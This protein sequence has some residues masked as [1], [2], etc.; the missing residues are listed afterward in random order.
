[1][2]TPVKARTHCTDG[3]ANLRTQVEDAEIKFP[4]CASNSSARERIVPGIVAWVVAATLAAAQVPPRT[5]NAPRAQA[6]NAPRAAIAQPLGLLFQVVNNLSDAVAAA[7]LERVHHEDMLLYSALTLLHQQSRLAPSAQREA[8]G[9]AITKLGRAVAE[10]HTVA[11]AGDLAKSE[12]Q[13]NLVQD[14]VE[15][16]KTFYERENL[17]RAAVLA[18]RYTCAA[19]PEISG[20]RNALC[21]RCSSILDQVVRVP[22]TGAA[23]AVCGVPSPRTMRADI[24]LEAP[25]QTG[26]QVRAIL[27][28]TKPNGTPVLASDLRE[29]HTQKIH[30]LLIDSSLDDYHHEHPRVTATPGDYA[31]E[32]TPRKPG[33]YRA[34][35][36][37]RPVA[38]GFH[39]SPM[40]EI[41][42][43]I[44][45]E[46]LSDKSLNLSAVCDGWRGEL[47][48]S[49]SEIRAGQP[50]PARLRLSGA[51]GTPVTQLEPLM[52]AFAH[53]AG[54]HE[55]RQSVLHIH[56]KGPPATNTEARGGPELEFIFYSHKAGF[57]RLFAQVQIAGVSRIFPFGI[58]VHR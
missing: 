17:D 9:A 19:H 26:A 16:L 20:A 41:Y 38:T 12:A 51:D 13:S 45:G 5:E 11:D 18:G 22:L 58:H 43:D 55:D 36:D 7:Q 46:L 33:G 1:M 40:A 52:A 34:W 57:V 56:P 50:V 54:F 27:R 39:E 53:F 49:P 25:W 42:P 10:L 8:L 32:F 28:L 21:P 31:F 14:A 37:L 24:R 48:F 29:T 47:R 15:H 2:R 3:K 30:L 4:M 35:A 6:S 23:D 44:A